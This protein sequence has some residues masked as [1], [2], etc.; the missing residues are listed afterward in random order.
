MTKFHYAGK[1]QAF[2]RQFA[3]GGGIPDVKAPPIPELTPEQKAAIAMGYRGP[4][5]NVSSAS[6]QASA[7]STSQSTTTPGKT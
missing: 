2:A 4:P 3:A 1:D 7:S 6:G 5:M